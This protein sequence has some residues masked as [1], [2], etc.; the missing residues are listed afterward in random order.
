MNLFR[1]SHRIRA[2]KGQG[3]AEYALILLFVSVAAMIAVTIL[4]P[5]VTDIFDRFVG[6]E[7]IAPPALANYQAP[8]TAT[9]DPFYTP[10]PTNTP[11]P[12]ATATPTNGPANTPTPTATTF[13]VPTN[14]PRPSNCSTFE[15]ESGVLSGLM[16]IGNDGDASGG[17]FVH[18]PN[19]NGDNF[20]GA[21]SN[22]VTFNV[23]ISNAG[24]YTIAGNVYATNG[25]DDSFWV[26]IDNVQALWDMGQN[27][28]YLE[29]YVSNRNGDDPMIYS[30]SPGTYPLTFSLREDGA[31]LD[32][33]AV[34][35][36]DSASASQF[37]LPTDNLCL[38]ATT[39][40]SSTAYSGSSSL[41]CDGNRDGVYNNGSVTH[42]QNEANAWW[43]VDLG[44][45]N[46]LQ[47]IKIFNRTDCCGSRLSNFHVFVS[48]DPFLSTDLNATLNQPGVD[49]FFFEGNIDSLAYAFTK[50]TGRY[51]RIQLTNNSPLSLA[52]VEI[53]GSRE[54]PDACTAVIDMFYIIDQSGSMNYAISGAINRMAASRSAITTVNNEMVASGLPHRVGAVSY[55]S[56]SFYYSDGFYRY[57]INNTTYD[58]TADIDGF[59]NDTLPYII[60]GGL[61][62]IGPA[63]NDAR[64][65]MIDTW[66]PLRIPVI[67][68]LTDGAPNVARDEIGYDAAEAANIDVYDSSGDPYPFSTIATF[69]SSVQGSSLKQGNILVDVLE[70]TE[71]LMRSLPNA[72]LHTIGLGDPSASEFNAQLMQY[73]ADI[74]GGNYYSA[75]SASDLTTALTEIYNSV[76]SC[77][78]DS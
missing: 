34:C 36:D 53:Y 20:A 77:A 22:S 71:D 2:Q 37:L 18:V 56:L 30:L 19:G 42:T 17:S 7:E 21:N 65:S 43:Q 47:Q 27:S 9:V 12:F 70:S 74:G 67:I 28:S 5:S 44:R 10:V 76:P 15:A 62:P 72:T 24:D 75:N 39:S 8:P 33:V 63:L 35:F 64:L 60:P 55:R 1:Q 40:Q 48:D 50:Q 23:T 59:T 57:T 38:N 54:V 69:G 68:L 45:V 51:I 49:S 31:R 29:D 61:T 11:N 73:V 66:D 14:T 4:E 6:R 3:F 46:A 52:E 41:A 26:T 13:I 58:T 78:A 25:S 32:K 16:Q